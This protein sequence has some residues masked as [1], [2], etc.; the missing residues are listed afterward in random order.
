LPAGALAEA[1]VRVL[2]RVLAHVLVVGSA[3]ASDGESK[4]DGE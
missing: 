4:A 2:A 1:L 3:S